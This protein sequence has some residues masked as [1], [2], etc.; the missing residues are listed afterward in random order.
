M[1]DKRFQWVSFY[2]EFATKLLV[3]KNERALLIQ[4]IKKVYEDI[5]LK[6]PKLESDNHPTDIDPFTV[7]GLLIRESVM[8]TGL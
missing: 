5:H 4:K 8:G 7:Y 2:T 6:F 3:Y 1:K